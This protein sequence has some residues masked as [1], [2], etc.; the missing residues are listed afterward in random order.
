MLA[1]MPQFMLIHRHSAG[2]CRVA[3]AS[4]RGFDSPLRKAGA[5]GSCVL[6][7]GT[8]DHEIWWTVEAPDEAS[9]LTQLPPY[10]AERTQARE[11]GE[12]SIP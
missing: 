4:W 5:I 11:V 8:A 2:E 12:V 7:D 6:V 9:A 1:R 10:I 3:F